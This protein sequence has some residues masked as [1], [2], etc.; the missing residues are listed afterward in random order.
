TNK[1]SELINDL[2][3]NYNQHP[4]YYSLI[5][6]LSNTLSKRV[7][8]TNQV[9]V[10]SLKNELKLSRA[11]VVMSR[12]MLNMLFFLALYMYAFKIIENLEGTHVPSIAISI[13]L[14]LVF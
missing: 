14:I 4:V 11:R 3:L 1:L 10:E 9:T 13:P 6:N 2:K 5:S 12:F 8:D 7:R